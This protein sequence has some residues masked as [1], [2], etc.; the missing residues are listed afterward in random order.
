M[1]P[2]HSSGPMLRDTVF[3]K[4]LVATGITGEDAWSRP[5]PHPLKISVSLRTDFKKA[6]ATD[7]LKYSLNY[8]VLSRNIAEYMRANEK[9]N[10]KSLGRVA[11]SIAEVVLDESIGGGR[12]AEVIVRSDKSSI[13]ADAIEYH[14]ERSKT[15]KVVQD[16]ICI[17]GLRLL[18]VIGVFT[19]ERLKKQIVDID[20]DL[21]VK[22]NTHSETNKIVDEVTEYVETSN[23]KTVE[24]F[25]SSIGQFILQNNSSCISKLKVVATKPNAIAYTE[26]VGV[27]TEIYD[28]ELSSAQIK[29]NNVTNE[30]SSKVPVTEKTFNLPTTASDSAFGASRSHEAYI[31]FGSNEGNQVNN[32]ADALDHLKDF[33]INVMAT[34]SLYISKPMYFKD[35]PDFF[36][37]V[38]KVTFEDK[39]PH[40]LLK[41]LKSIEYDYLK[42]IKQFE[43]GPR[44]IDLDILL[45]DNVSLN[46]SDLTI[47]HKSMLERSFVLQPLCELLGPDYIHPVSAE[48]IHDHLRQLSGSQTDDA[49]QESSKI[50]QIVPISRLDPIANPLRFDH[51][52]NTHRTLIMGILNVTPDSFS[53]GG[54]HYSLKPADIEERVFTLLKQGADIIDI[55]GLSTRPGSD[56]PPLQ[57]E[58][59]RVIP[60]IKAIRD[61]SDQQVAN[62]VISVDTYRGEIAEKCLQAGA[63]IINDVSMGLYDDTL[64]D[65]VARH[66]CPYIVSHTRGTPKT[67]SKLTVYNSNTDEDIIENL[68]DIS[69]G[70]TITLTNPATE[71]LVKGVSRELALQLLK[72]FDRGIKKW[73]IVVDPGVGFAKNL[74]QNL[75]LIK[76]AST[77]KSYSVEVNRRSTTDPSNVNH[78]YISFY[79]SPILL[80]TSRK[81]FLGTIC[82]QANPSERVIS[83]AASVV[84]CIEQKTDIVRVHDVGEIKDAVLIA[85]AIYK[86]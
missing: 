77:F 51:N 45:F 62:A 34:S 17:K 47:P 81:K 78:H 1:R 33:G 41:I 50:Y 56:E 64:F 6:S 20:L 61:S 21:Y 5:T 14:L 27:S 9:R 75:S 86:S 53:D 49:I 42:R 85:D 31:A 8:A 52:E 80:G 11:E 13:R 36:N 22:E 43:N 60:A 39:S 3:I 84:A 25:V 30:T 4:D 29:F 16:R 38:V 74:E 63:D 54:K 79:G 12:H 7:N 57:E 40:Q 23:F 71:N 67:M 15:E 19:F 46:E 32:I 24:A 28:S 59:D 82:D 73:Q 65:V 76:T 18:T 66:G 55:G 48:P 70:Q 69:N 2:I 44:A 37:G 68:V 26:G 58:L 83:T 35:Q 10:F 72:A